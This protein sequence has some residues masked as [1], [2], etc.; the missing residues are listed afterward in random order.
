[1][2]ASGVR[3][4]MRVLWTHNFDPAI[5]NSQVY[6]NIAAGGLRSLGVDLH[7]EFLGNLR[8]IRNLQ[9][10]RQRVR[11]LAPGFDVIHA[12]YGSACALATA[13]AAGCPKVLTL[14]G[15]DWSVGNRSAFQFVHTR[16]ARAMTRWALPEYDCVA[17]VSE[18]MGREV[19]ADFPQLEMLPL[20]SPVNLDKFVLRDRAEARRSLGCAAEGEKWVLFNALSLNDPVK[21]FPLARAAFELARKKHPG[22]RLKLAT[23]MPHEDIRVL[24]SACDLILLTSETEG[25]PNCIKEALACN[26]PFVATDVGDLSAIARQES[27]CRV[28]AAT[29]QALAEGICA[30]LEAGPATS[31]RRHIEGMSLP[32]LSRRLL[33]TYTRLHQHHRAKAC[34]QPTT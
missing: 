2:P 11:A 15:N 8:S 19:T 4:N 5:P 31:L 30:S 10:A 24:V 27:S 12:Q 25:W 7:L 13:A 22:L 34:A 20:P 28:C 29:P 21:R 32:V 3:L 17:V 14:R 16:L 23:E 9:R 6:I 1:M 18:R 33:E 26:V